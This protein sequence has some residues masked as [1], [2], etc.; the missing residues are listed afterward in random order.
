MKRRRA[1]EYAL[2]LLFQLDITGDRLSDELLDEFWEGNKE[3][4][5]VRD[6]ADSIVRGTIGHLDTIDSLIRDAT[7]HWELERMPVIDRNILRAA[8]YELLYR[9]DIPPSVAINEAIEL[10]K[11]YST[12]DSYRF[13]NGVLDRIQQSRIRA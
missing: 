13:I 7:E 10:A 12:E 11:K 8:T 2:Q 9:P 1:R 6:F 4:S 5:E 3:D